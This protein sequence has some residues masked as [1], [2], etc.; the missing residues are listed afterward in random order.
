LQKIDAIKSLNPSKIKSLEQQLKTYT[1]KEDN[2]L[3][4]CVS[5]G[6]VVH[7]KRELLKYIYQIDLNEFLGIDD[8]EFINC[9]LPDHKDNDPS[10]HIYTTKDG[11]QVYKCFGCDKTLTIVSLVETLARTSRR[12]AIDFIKKVYD[13]KLVESEWTKEQREILSENMWYLDSEEFEIQFP[14]LSRLIRTRKHHIQ[15]MMM[16]FSSLIDETIQLNDRPLFFLSYDKLLDVCGIRNNN[17]TSLSKSLILFNL[18]NMMDKIDPDELPVEQ[19]KK[20]KSISAKYGLKKLTNFYQFNEYGYLIFEKSEEIAKKLI[21]NNMSI[22]GISR[23]YILR[24]FGIELADKVFPQFRYENHKFGT[25]NKSNDLTM[26]ISKSLLKVIEK[27][28]YIM[29]SKIKINDKIETQW[30]KS[31]QEILDTYN[32]VRV[33]ASKANKEKYNLPDKIPYQSFVICKNI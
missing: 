14:N 31:I 25:S 13:I 5:S 26:K 27:Q 29:E 24:T 18:L 19:L 28:G 8:G 33:K 21:E 6:V 3:S 11:T 22:K 16:Y 2:L 9:I 32:L 17:R 7:S 12:K 30:K 10:A 15:K 20:A 23:E 4:V 1:D